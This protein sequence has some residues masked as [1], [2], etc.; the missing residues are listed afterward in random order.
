MDSA[1]KSFECTI[2][3]GEAV[4]RICAEPDCFN[5][6][7]CLDCA[8]ESHEKNHAPSFKK[9]KE[10]LIQ[11]SG[12]LDST[13]SQLKLDGKPPVELVE[14][15]NKQESTINALE[16]QISVLT[17][18][19]NQ[20]FDELLKEL[21]TKINKLRNQVTCGYA[22]QIQTMK[23]NFQLFK[24]K[25]KKYYGESTSSNSLEDMIKNIENCN[26]A[27]E[28][29]LFIKKLKAEI[30]D[31]A[32]IKNGTDNIRGDIFNKL[33][34][35]KIDMIE[36]LKYVPKINVDDF[37]QNL[38]NPLKDHLEKE[39]LNKMNLAVKIDPVTM[40]SCNIKS[41]I[42]KQAD[43]LN[44][45]QKWLGLSDKRV[46]YT[47]L[48][49]GTKEQFSARVFHQ[50]VDSIEHTLILARTDKKSIYGGYADITWNITNAYKYS[51]EVFVFDLNQKK[52]YPITPGREG[53]AMYPTANNGPVFGASEFIC[54]SQNQPRL[55]FS[56]RQTFLNNPNVNQ[57]GLFGGQLNTLINDAL[58][59]MEVFQINYE[60]IPKPGLFQNHQAPQ[61]LFQNHP[62]QQNAFQ[63]PQSGLFS[64]K[65]NVAK[66]V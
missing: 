34:E 60:G 18:Q 4:Q 12:V 64:M 23:S 43:Q 5:P 17:N 10:Y 32:L 52:K 54:I 20:Y 30:E 25:I 11:V 15:L 35:Y 16:K 27:H 28:Y 65:H 21:T 3:K 33:M 66:N 31:V 48:F 13:R 40:N 49:K 51:K 56:P 8:L 19:S 63:Q 45:I 9:I 47:L 53:N 7:L 41:S 2:H 62:M 55:Y 57:G 58:E 36:S 1:I 6:L 24:D 59:E 61:G 42:V 37:T 46:T 39:I 14:V 38:L 26:D 44:L 29:T 22:E 50:K